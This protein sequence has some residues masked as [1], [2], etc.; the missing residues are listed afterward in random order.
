MISLLKF[1]GYINLGISLLH[2]VGLLWANEMFQFTGVKNEMD[3]LSTVHISLPYL[4]TVLVGIIFAIFGVYALSV[5]NRTSKLPYKKTVIYGVALLY[6][7]RG[8]GELFV[9]SLDYSMNASETL[10]SGIAITV[11]AAYGLG[12]YFRFKKT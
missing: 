11:G 12:G 3:K 6:L 4:L 1:G 5:G 7:I 8:L 9:D 10:F 2:F